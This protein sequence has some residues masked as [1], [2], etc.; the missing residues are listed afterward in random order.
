MNV[1]LRAAQGEYIG[2]VESDDFAGAEMFAA[3][4]G[5][6][7]AHDAEVVRSNF[8]EATDAGSTFREELAGHPYGEIFCPME[9]DPE[10][11]LA[12]P[13]IWSAIYRRSFLLEHDIWFHETPGASFQ[14]LSFSF[15]VLS[16]AQKYFLVHE[17]YLHYRIDNAG[18]S[19][20][21][22]GKIFCVSDE[23]DYM[24]AF[25]QKHGRSAM[26]HQWAAKLFF[27]HIMANES[28]IA[29]AYWGRF[30]Q[31]ALEQL[32]QAHRHGWFDH[33]LTENPKAWLMQRLSVRQQRKLAVAGFWLGLHG[34][35]HVYL[36]GAGQV[37][38]GLLKEMGCHGIHASGMIVS[39]LEGN[40][41]EVA[42]VPVYTLENAP[43]DREH[44]AVVIAVS[45]KKPEIQQ[46]IFLALEEAGY[47]NVIVLTEELRQAL[48][49]A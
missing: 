10:L 17:A 48:A 5:V 36:Y 6:A 16:S 15:L 4:D 47:R 18:S 37:A 34:A 13:N 14:D 45:P 20:H 35:P 21:S 32:M 30:W 2:I 1:G 31:R 22:K 27:Q 49:E 8:W 12:L 23:Y 40:P 24:E 46:E 19:V 11:L 44:D 41:A 33:A 29:P 26:Q 9:R 42:G 43:A 28:R 3:L 38:K 7:K 39:Q 25:L